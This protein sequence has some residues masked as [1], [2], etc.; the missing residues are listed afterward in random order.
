MTTERF[1][2]VRRMIVSKNQLAKLALFLLVAWAV[3]VPAQAKFKATVTKAEGFDA[4]TVSKVVVVTRQCHA[5]VDCSAIE[6]KIAAEIH[7][8]DLPFTPVPE[9]LVRQFLFDRG[10]TELTKELRTELAEEFGADALLEVSVPYAEK[11]DGFGGRRGSQVKVEIYLVRPGGEILVHGVGT[12]RPKN[13]VSG[14][15]RVAGNI[16]ERIL[17]KAFGSR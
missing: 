14:P 13:V 7:A 9:L 5:V 17:K 10:T 11:G 3:A 12:G 1:D 2:T 15:E 16:A 8:L 4:E 6:R